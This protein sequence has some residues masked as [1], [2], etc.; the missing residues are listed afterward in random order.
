MLI[1][2][3]P[4]AYQFI[5]MDNGTLNSSDWINTVDNL[6]TYKMIPISKIERHHVVSTKSSV[7]FG[8]VL[9]GDKQFLEYNTLAGTPVLDGSNVSVYYFTSIA[10]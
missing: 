4:N 9:N 5:V 3:E 8:V 2:T 6:Y 10:L 1:F 7:T